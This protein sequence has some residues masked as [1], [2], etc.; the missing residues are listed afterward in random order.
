MILAIGLDQTIGQQGPS[1][2]FKAIGLCV[3]LSVLYV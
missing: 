2:L 3:F 1:A